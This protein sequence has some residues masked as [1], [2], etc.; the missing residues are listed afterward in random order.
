MRNA[1]SYCAIRVAISG[2]F[3][4]SNSSWFSFPRSPMN[5]ARCDL[6][7][8]CRI[9]DIQHRVA[10]RSQLDPLI[11]ARNESRAPLSLGQRLAVPGNHHDEGRQVLVD[12]PQTVGDPG[13]EARPSRQLKPGLRERHR[14]VVIDLFGVHRLD[15]AQVVGDLRGVGQ[16]FAQPRARF[17]V[18]R[19]LEDRLRDRKAASAPRSSPSTAG[20][21][22]SNRAGRCP[23][24]WRAAA[25]S[26]TGRAAT[27]AP[28]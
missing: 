22:G 24:P 7:K 2:L 9:G 20:R 12:G 27:G 16:Q 25:C 14:R 18:L 4:A 13:A 28:L 21:S 15:E 6:S 17:S 8:P 26:R 11:P 10:D 1:I 3:V 19:K 5:R 23:A